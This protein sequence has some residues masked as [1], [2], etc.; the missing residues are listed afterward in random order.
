[1]QAWR[2]TILAPHLPVCTPAELPKPYLLARVTSLPDI[3][4]SPEH[5][6]FCREWKSGIEIARILTGYLGIGV[7]FDSCPPYPQRNLA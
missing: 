6:V 7:I 3:V 4:G 5:V 1:M 2:K